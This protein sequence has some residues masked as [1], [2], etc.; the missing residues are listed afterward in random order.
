MG[1]D[2]LGEGRLADKVKKQGFAHQE[3]MLDG[4]LRKVAR[5]DKGGTKRRFLVSLSWG[6]F[7]VAGGGGQCFVQQNKRMKGHF[8]LDTLY[9]PHNVGSVVL[10]EV[11]NAM[12]LCKKVF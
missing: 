3:F 1:G 10:G 12:K 7:L 2:W 9:S 8:V 11:P 4:L 5:A 6:A